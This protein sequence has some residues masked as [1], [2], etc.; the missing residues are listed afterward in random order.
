MAFA[1]VAAGAVV[2]GVVA[3][4]GAVVLAGA[5]LLAFA[6]LE[7]VLFL[8]FFFGC[9]GE[10]RPWNAWADAPRATS[11]ARRRAT[12]RSERNMSAGSP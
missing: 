5:V 12:G 2:A 1:G 8:A 7:L 6:L 10:S 4:A 11:S 9:C 3:L